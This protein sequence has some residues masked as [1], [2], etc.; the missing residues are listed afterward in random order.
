MIEIKETKRGFITPILT[1]KDYI[2]GDSQLV[3]EILRPDRQW[4]NSLPTEEIQNLLNYE[5]ANCTGFGSTNQI[6]IY[7]KE[8][9]G[10]IHNFSDRALGI[11]AGTYPPGND[12]QKVYEVIRK[13]G[14]AEDKL[15]PFGGNNVNDYFDK[16]KLTQEVKNSEFQFLNKYEFKHDW[17]ASGKKI[18]HSVMKEAL[19]YSP[20]A[21]AIFAFAFDGEYY[22]RAGEDGDWICITGYE[23]GKYWKG[24]TSYSPVVKKFAWDFGFYWVKRISI[25]KKSP[26]EQLEMTQKSLIIILLQ[27]VSILVKKLYRVGSG[28]VAGIFQKTD[29]G[30]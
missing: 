3:G 12:P 18:E 7:L 21:V 14:L 28:V 11:N 26:E 16:N 6:E 19:K 29:R 8:K 30:N 20:L 27:Y 10:E 15:L 23:D 24:Y 9:F 22:V 2:F 25:R 17:V 5:T 4:D 13:T 1:E